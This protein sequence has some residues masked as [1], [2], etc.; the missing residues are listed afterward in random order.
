[1]IK[2]IWK[3]FKEFEKGLS[4]EQKK[5][6]QVLLFLVKFGIASIPIY[7]IMALD[8]DFFYMQNMEA[9]QVNL[10][11]NSLG[12][13]STI[14]YCSGECSPSPPGMPTITYKSFAMGVDRAC[15]GYRS[16]FALIGLILAT[17]K[18]KIGKRK[19]GIVFAFAVIYMANIIR[20]VSTFYLSLDFD[21]EIIH[22][23]MWREGMIGVVFLSW[24]FWL[25]KL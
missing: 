17:P 20:L 22:N 9:I 7:I 2:K 1:M 15:T 14:Y 19:K 13:N 4:R 10:I 24:V 3:K 23:L 12:I 18:I 8:I 25:K 5:L 21:F 16:L 6:L 11:L